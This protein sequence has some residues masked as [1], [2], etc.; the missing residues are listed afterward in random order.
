[1]KKDLLY[2]K[3]E[4]LYV[5]EMRTYESIAAT[6]D[7]SPR[8]VRNWAAEGRWDVRRKR[9]LENKESLSDNAREIA[10]LMGEMI[11]GQLKE[12]IVPAA[13]LLN[14]FTRIASTLLQAHAYEKEVESDLSGEA[15]NNKAKEAALAQ[16]R[17]TFGVDLI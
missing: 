17:E 13:H 6:L 8:T 9:L 3:A 16:F 7:C 10:A 15:D 2:E 14:A 11:K 1:M 5:N 12:E 4:N